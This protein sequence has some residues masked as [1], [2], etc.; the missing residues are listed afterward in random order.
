MKFEEDQ[1]CP[2]PPGAA[3]A[4]SIL[5]FIFAESME[6]TSKGSW[7]TASCVERAIGLYVETPSS[8]P[9]PAL[10]IETPIWSCS[11]SQ[12]AVFDKPVRPNE[13]KQVPKKTETQHNPNPWPHQPQQQLHHQQQAPA[14]FGPM[15]LSTCSGYDF[16]HLC[17]NLNS[18]MTTT[19]LRGPVMPSSTALSCCGMLTFAQSSQFDAFTSFFQPACPRIWCA[20]VP[21]IAPLQAPVQAQQQHQQQQHQ[22]QQKQMAPRNK[23]STF[24]SLAPSSPSF[25]PNHF[26]SS[27]TLPLQKPHNSQKQPFQSNKPAGK[28]PAISF[29]NT[30]TQSRRPTSAQASPLSPLSTQTPW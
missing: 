24:S 22:Q 9:C 4:E 23:K 3:I 5:N 20:G 29:P 7:L 16:C 8:S 6:E 10:P 12:L 19:A 26:P 18:A 21:P 11:L 15:S 1:Q 25:P 17:H 28:K 30:R 27:Q 14:N 13:E 2:V